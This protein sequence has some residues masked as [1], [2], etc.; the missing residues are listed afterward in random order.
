[1]KCVHRS[2]TEVFNV[3]WSLVTEATIIILLLLYYCCL[4]QP[5]QKSEK[6]ETWK[7][8]RTQNWTTFREILFDIFFLGVTILYFCWSPTNHHSSV[9]FTYIP[10]VWWLKFPLNDEQIIEQSSLTGYFPMCLIVS[11][12]KQEDEPETPK[13]Q[14]KPSPPTTLS[15]NQAPTLFGHLS[16]ASTSGKFMTHTRGLLDMETKP[17]NKLWLHYVP[18][19][20]RYEVL[21]YTLSIRSIY[22]EWIGT[23]S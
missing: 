16:Q 14:G 3:M 9:V 18:N 1:M 13:E 23:H 8:W 20:S 6:L 4:K 15:Y 2:T 10:I 22:L 5:K 12:W 17:W 19:A 21:L 11:K 7:W